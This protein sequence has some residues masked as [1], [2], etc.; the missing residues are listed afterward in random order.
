MRKFWQRFRRNKFALIG[1]C[2]LTV[3]ILAAV[4]APLLAPHD[5]N[6]ANLRM[7]NQPPSR[8]YPFG[9]DDM[10][11]DILSRLLYG[12]RISLSVGLVSVGISLSI[13]LVLGSLAG[14]FGGF[15]D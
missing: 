8:E 1:L 2:I 6:R 12:G 3:F 13:G 11:R 9:T 14:Y 7:R 4:F 10:G 5:P 15:V